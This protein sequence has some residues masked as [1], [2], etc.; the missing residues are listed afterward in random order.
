MNKTLNSKYTFNRERHYF[1]VDSNS[2]E[3]IA[4]HSTPSFIFG[5][6][7]SINDSPMIHI[8]RKN[9]KKYKCFAKYFSIKKNSTF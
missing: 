9:T 6:Q 5:W 8:S 2:I 3:I 7:S 4:S 1:Y